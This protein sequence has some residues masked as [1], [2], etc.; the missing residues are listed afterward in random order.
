LSSTGI[1]ACAR[2]QTR[3]GSRMLGLLAIAFFRGS[4]A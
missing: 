2:V 1:P 4:A 3:R